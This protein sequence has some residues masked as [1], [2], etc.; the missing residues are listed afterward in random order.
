MTVSLWEQ[1]YAGTE[2]MAQTYVQT[3]HW[4][5][6]DEYLAINLLLGARL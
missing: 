2:I 4:R 1:I 3:D 6:H 5:A